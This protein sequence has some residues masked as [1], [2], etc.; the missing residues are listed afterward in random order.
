VVAGQVRV[1]NLGTD[2]SPSTNIELYLSE[3]TGNFPTNQNRLILEHNAVVPGATIAGSVG[4]YVIN[5][6]YTFSTLGRYVLL[7]RVVNNSPPAR[8]ACTQQGYDTSSPATDAQTA[9]HYLN[10]VE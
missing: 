10:V 3:P 4:E 9:I 5:W 6:S 2:D 8:A 7:A 1:N